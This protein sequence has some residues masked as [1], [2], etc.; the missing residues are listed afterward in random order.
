[1]EPWIIFSV[2]TFLVILLSATFKYLITKKKIK[3]TI[4]SKIF[5]YDDETFIKSWRKTK[6]KGLLIFVIKSAIYYT[7]YLVI[8]FGITFLNVN[9]GKSYLY[10]NRLLLIIVF[11]IFVGFGCLLTPIKWNMQQDKYSKLTDMEQIENDNN[12]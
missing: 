3:A 1:M 11:A 9:G 10:E 8:L 2:I 6:E 4:V 7:F 12:K 5:Y